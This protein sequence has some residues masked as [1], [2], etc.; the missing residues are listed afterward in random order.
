MDTD[1]ERDPWG[2]LRT[3]GTLDTQEFSMRKEQQR[4][5]R[6]VYGMTATQNGDLV[7]RSIPTCFAALVILL[8]AA[9]GSASAAEFGY[10]LAAGNF[11]KA[12]TVG[13]EGDIWFIGRTLGKVTSEGAVSEY[14]YAAPRSST[15]GRP[16]I[17]TGLD[18]NLW[19]TAANAIGRST[20]TGEVS[21]FELPSADA[22]P[23]AI[24]AGPD[25]NLWF[26]EQGAG[27][28]A[29]ITPGG[30]LTEFPLAEG[31]EPDA[32][33]VGPDRA[34]WFADHK[35][36]RIGRIS[37]SGELVTFRVPGAPAKLA[38]IT[39]GP[40]GNLWFTEEAQA[41]VGR[42]TPQGEVTQF[43][44]PTTGGTRAIIAGPGGLL[45][46][47]SR[48]EIGAISTS[49]QISWPACLVEHCV[50][51]PESL[52]AGPEGD[53]WVSSG[54]EHCGGPCG[55]STEM[56]FQFRPGGIG[57]FVLPPLR[58]GIGPRVAPIHHRMTTIS[59]ACGGSGDCRG[60]LRLGSYQH[61]NGKNYFRA[62]ATSPYDLPAGEAK[63][64]P[65]RFSR[66][67]LERLPRRSP[68]ILTILA[69]PKG[70]VI[71]ARSL[72]QRWR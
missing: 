34:L 47:T 55:G 66:R 44:V 58:L 29:S 46:F 21:F 45:W 69:G 52:L 25:G 8:F 49:G 30:A 24:V 64:V 59:L 61:R 1:A 42:I 36:N 65:L 57:R 56:S 20:T 63:R 38:S 16:S 50:A 2:G 53:L 11:A 37:T 7:P 71:A 14:P 23:T 33:T 60:V 35:T 48:Y 70:K 39:A 18:G 68:T 3:I 51:P 22:K 13:P 28:I 10:P 31:S 4:R 9:G 15:S 67:A 6:A 27:A 72:Y 41:T 32:L 19:F 12:T 17:A 5:P 54:V 40:D 26:A 62:L 43:S